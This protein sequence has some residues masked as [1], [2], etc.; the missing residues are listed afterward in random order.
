MRHGATVHHHKHIN[1]FLFCKCFFFSGKTYG[2]SKGET[3]EAGIHKEKGMGDAGD[4]YW[5][6][7]GSRPTEAMRRK[8]LG[9]T[10]VARR[11]RSNRIGS[12][13]APYPLR[14]FTERVR[15]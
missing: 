12:V 2:F 14:S 9:F 8:A 13:S 1:F 4:I 3:D 10:K 11:K 5:A 15:R 6:T 7:G